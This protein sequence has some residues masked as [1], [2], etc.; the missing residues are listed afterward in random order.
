MR[1]RELFEVRRPLS[2][3]LTL[4]LGSIF[5]VLVLLAWAFVTA[6]PVEERIVSPVILPSPGEILESLPSLIERRELGSNTWVSFV[7]VVKGFGLAVLV[8]VPLGLLMGSFGPVKAFF[9]PLNVIAGYLPLITIIP[10]SFAW[11]LPIG[12][13]FQKLMFLALACS[14]YM[15]PMVVGAVENVDETFVNTAQTLG[16]N[17][18]ELV[19]KVLFPIALP[20]IYQAARLAFGVGWTWIIVAETLLADKGLGFIFMTS[21]RFEKPHMYWTALVILV[22]G[23]LTDRIL[24]VLGRR[25]FPYRYL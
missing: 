12:E 7:R 15:L 21:Y 19:G 3:G 16:A 18:L 2:R 14:F 24:D 6:G 13:E 20:D 5:C 23:F 10:L 1:P 8:V 17:R 11:F 9:E 25:L 22:I 4:A